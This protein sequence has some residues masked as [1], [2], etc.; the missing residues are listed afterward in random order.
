MKLNKNS[1]LSVIAV[2]GVGILTLFWLK[3]GGN[4]GD[5]SLAKISGGN[6]PSVPGTAPTDDPKQVFKNL[7]ELPGFHRADLKGSYVL[8]HFWAK[9]CEP[10]AEEIPQL[11]EFAKNPGFPAK[12]KIVAVSLDPNLDESKTILPEQGKNLPAS[13]LLF[14]DSEHKVAEKMGSYQYP[15]TYFV[16]PTGAV[17]EKWIGPQK[18]TKPEVLDFFVKRIQ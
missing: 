3:S 9:W 17:L 16:D 5:F 10:C 18:W 12:L 11:V 15:E 13:F 8:V 6:A 4:A 1:V 14:L 2:V 7:S